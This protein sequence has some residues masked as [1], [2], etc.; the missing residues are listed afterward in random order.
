MKLLGVYDNMFAVICKTVYE[1]LARTGVEIDVLGHYGL[2]NLFQ[3][4]TR[5]PAVSFRNYHRVLPISWT[6][7][8]PPLA[9]LRQFYQDLFWRRLF[10]RY[11]AVILSSTLQSIFLPLCR[12]RMV[13]IL[14]DPY[15]LL[16]RRNDYGDE[17]ALIERADIIL[18]T[19]ANLKNRYLPKYFNHSG[20]NAWYWPNTVDLA[21]WDFERLKALRRRNEKPVVGFAGNFLRITVDLSLLDVVTDRFPDVEFRFAGRVAEQDD[22]YAPRLERIFRKPNVRH[23]G[24]IPFDHIREEIIAW[25]VCLLLDDSSELSSYV[26][27]NKIYQYLALGKPVVATRPHA[28]YDSL[29]PTVL[30]SGSTSEYLE[31]LAKALERKDDPRYVQEGIALA[32]ANSSDVRATAALKILRDALGLE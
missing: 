7:R 26:H 5:S 12:R 32:R 11:D 27:H 25:D 9:H 29:A 2:P 22:G 23:L 4:R 21:E 28:D 19:N 16:G 8:H 30:L 6:R 3:A 31:N 14:C 24:W 1:A 10:D 17:K 13:F 18:A 20:A 15:H